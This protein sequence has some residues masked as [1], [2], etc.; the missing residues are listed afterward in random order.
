MNLS[1]VREQAGRLLNLAATEED[2]YKA[3]LMREVAQATAELASLA[4][5][6]RAMMY[7]GTVGDG[8]PTWEPDM[9]V[10]G[11]DLVEWVGNEMNELGLIPKRGPR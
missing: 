4:A 5:G 6:L 1:R 2:G 11:A 3:D 8:L 7:G 9:H 10:S